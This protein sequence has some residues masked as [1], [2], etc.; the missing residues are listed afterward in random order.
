M[1]DEGKNEM[2]S[3]V[4]GEGLASVLNVQSLSF[5]IFKKRICATVRRNVEPNN[6]LLTRTLPFDSDIRQ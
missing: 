5:F 2:L 3:D 4:G 6:I 1:R